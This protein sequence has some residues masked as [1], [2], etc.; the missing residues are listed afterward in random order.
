MHPPFKTGTLFGG[1][2]DEK[3]HQNACVFVYYIILCMFCLILDMYLLEIILYNQGTKVIK[4]LE[5]ARLQIKVEK[6][7]SYGREEI[8]KMV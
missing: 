2:I 8:P 1:Q 4:N 3:D 5:T 6:E 7:I